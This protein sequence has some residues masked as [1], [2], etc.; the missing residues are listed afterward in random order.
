M[1]RLRFFLPALLLSFLSFSCGTSLK[2]AAINADMSLVELGMTKENVMK[3]IGPPNMVVSSRITDEGTLEVVEY[4]RQEPDHYV[5]KMVY[6]PIWLSFVDGKLVEWKPGENWQL[7][8][9]L[10]LKHAEGKGRTLR[11]SER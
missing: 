7:E 9:H 11:P 5:D 6:R 3:A 1:N 4:L 8:N 10:R 2:Y